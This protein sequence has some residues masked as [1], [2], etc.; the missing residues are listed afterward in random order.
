MDEVVM[1]LHIAF[2]RLYKPLV[3]LGLIL[4]ILGAAFVVQQV[5]AHSQAAPQTLASP[6]HPT[7]PMLDV[8]GKNVLESGAAVSTIKTCGQCHDADF[9]TSHSFHSDLGQSDQTAPGQVP[10]GQPWD[11]RSHSKSLLAFRL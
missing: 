5:Y 1:S 10:G 2:K 4:L 3:G 7:F 6:L 11:R 9:I 8:E